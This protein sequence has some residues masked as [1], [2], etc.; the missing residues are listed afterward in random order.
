VSDRRFFT[1]RD[2]SES[3]AVSI[4][5]VLAWIKSGQLRATDVSRAAG[6]KPRWRI[7]PSDLAAFE[8]TRSSTPMPKPQRRRRKAETPVKEYV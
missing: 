3:R 5:V 6:K 8:E 2:I 1:V 4:D 7:A